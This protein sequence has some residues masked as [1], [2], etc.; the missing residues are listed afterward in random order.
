MWAGSSQPESASDLPLSE[1]AELHK[2]AQKHQHREQAAETARAKRAM[3]TG[4]VLEGL[5][6]QAQM[7]YVYED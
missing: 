3:L 4:A 1:Q 5:L 6:R 7:P 2:R